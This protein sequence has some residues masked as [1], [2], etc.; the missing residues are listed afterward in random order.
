M[1]PGNLC[2]FDPTIEWPSVQPTDEEVRGKA[3]FAVQQLLTKLMSLPL[4]G[5]AGAF[6]FLFVT[7]LCAKTY[8][9]I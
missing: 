3:Q 8:F 4:V 6:V 1:D 7:R 5:N 9:S 2:A